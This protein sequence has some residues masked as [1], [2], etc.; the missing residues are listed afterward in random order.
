MSVSEPEPIATTTPTLRCRYCRSAPRPTFTT[1]AERDEHIRITHKS[2]A[3]IDLF[4]TTI[5]IERNADSTFH[6]PV[7]R[8]KNREKEEDALRIHVQ[9]LHE[10]N[11]SWTEIQIA[12]GSTVYV[13]RPATPASPSLTE[14]RMEPTNFQGTGMHSF[15]MD[16]MAMPP[17][18]KRR[19]TED[20][21]DDT[22]GPPAIM[23]STQAPSQTI[24]PLEDQVERLKTATRKRIADEMLNAY[25]PGGDFNLAM[26]NVEAINRF[27][28]ECLRGL[29]ELESTRKG[30]TRS[31]ATN[32]NILAN[33]G[34]DP[35][36]SVMPNGELVGD[37]IWSMLRTS[38]PYASEQVRH[39][40]SDGLDA[41]MFPPGGYGQ[42]GARS[43]DGQEI[44][45]TGVDEDGVPLDQP[46]PKIT[47]WKK[48]MMSW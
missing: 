26:R 3:N 28:A 21:T 12:A 10:D 35:S 39:Q 11:E 43:V 36:V 42:Q 16:R 32:D 14:P 13:K 37:G 46:K 38:E 40:E 6:C 20:T 30:T 4:N 34:Q 9:T 25:A 29:Q 2:F 44:E 31:D 15:D 1:V 5:L 7:G 41:G 23:P 24:E 33:L 45:Q 27:H 47:F 8:C 22:M 18:A 48:G 19:R 17:P